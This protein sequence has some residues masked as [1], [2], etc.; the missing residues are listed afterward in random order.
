MNLIER[1]TNGIHELNLLLLAV[2]FRARLR[3]ALQSTARSNEIDEISVHHNKK[4]K[5]LIKYFD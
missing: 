5:P 2:D 1:R 4:N 3:L